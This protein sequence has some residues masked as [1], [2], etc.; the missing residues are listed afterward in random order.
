MKFPRNLKNMQP[1]ESHSFSFET[2]FERLEKILDQLNGG[3][4]SLDD[5]LKLYEEADQLMA[6]CNKRLNDAER[7]IEILIK[8]RNGELVLGNETKPL[9]QEFTPSNFIPK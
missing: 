8:N 9:T 7:K 3:A 1:Q 6:I 2:A 5:A 4:V